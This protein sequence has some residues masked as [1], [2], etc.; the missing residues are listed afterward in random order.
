MNDRIVRWLDDHPTVFV[1]LYCG[2]FFAVM[3]VVQLAALSWGAK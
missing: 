1:L 2:A 3:A